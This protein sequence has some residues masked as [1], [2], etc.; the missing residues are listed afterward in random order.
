MCTPRA[1]YK[2]CEVAR[3][4]ASFAVVVTADAT[5]TRD[6]VSRPSQPNCIT[7]QMLVHH[8]IVT[9]DIISK[10][11]VNFEYQSA[12]RKEATMIK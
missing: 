9:V 3:V 1:G 8:P 11:T 4:N 10:R 7:A 6:W 2:P 5:S 12:L